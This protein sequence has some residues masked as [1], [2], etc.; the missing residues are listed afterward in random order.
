MRLILPA[1]LVLLTLPVHAQT[2]DQQPIID[3]HLH[4]HPYSDLLPREEP[5][6]GLMAPKANEQIQEQTLEALERNNVV[7]AVTSGSLVDSYQQSAPDRIVEGCAGGAPDAVRERITEGDCQVVAEMSPQYAGMAPDDPR[8]APYFA[9]ADSLDVPVGIHMGL[10]PPGAAYNY[11]GLEKYRMKLSN[12]LLLEE[13]LVH[14]PD[15]P[16]YVMHAGWP[17]LDEMIGLLHAHPQVYLDVSVINWVLPK[18]EFYRYLRRLVEA[19]FGDRIMY[20]S[21]QMQWPQAIERSIERI[22]SAP[23]L[24]EEQKR[25]ILYNNA[26]RFLR[27]SD[28]EIAQHHKR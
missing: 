27:L 14:H 10:G 25:D 21:D 26:A 4:A 1:A 19:G 3:M 7:L 24:T 23:F 5:M 18:A 15:L 13:A 22:Q 11:E 28:E 12:P 16:V 8:V 17:M 20:G 6:T 9:L 2:Q